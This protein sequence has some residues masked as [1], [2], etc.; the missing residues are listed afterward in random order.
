MHEEMFIF[1]YKGNENQSDTEIPS[2][3][4]M[5]NIK[6][7]TNVGEDVRKKEHLHCWWECKLVHPQW[8]SEWGFSRM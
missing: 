4:R 8:K 2:L 6:K 1:S 3:V 7:Q 5:A